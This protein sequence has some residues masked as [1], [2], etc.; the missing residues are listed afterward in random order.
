MLGLY[1]AVTRATLDG[2]NPGGWIPEEKITLPEAVEAYTMS[3]AFAEFQE[4]DKGSIT[5][6]KLGDMVILSDNIFDL[7][8][9]AIRNAKVETTIVGGQV[10][11]GPARNR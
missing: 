2:K 4:K 6:G 11:Y 9:E 10:V 8:P 5:P 3:S 1:A 7:K